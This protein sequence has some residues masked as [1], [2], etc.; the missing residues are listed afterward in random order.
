MPQPESVQRARRDLGNKLRALRTS[1]GF[2]GKALAAICDWHPSKVSRIENGRCSASVDD[3][4]AWTQACGRPEDAPE[5]VL[6]VE[7]I[8]TMYLEWREMEKKGLAKAQEHVI[9]L[10]EDTLRYKAYAI[11]YIPG[12]FQTEDYTRAV[13][14]GI[15]TRRGL[16]DEDFDNAVAI[17][18]AKQKYL[19]S[20]QFRIVLEEDVLYTRYAGR[21]VMISQLTRLI[22]VADY[23]SVSL[24]IIPRDA[25]R[26]AAHKA[27]DF[28]IFDDRTVQVE[29]VSAFLTLKQQHEVKRYLDDFHYL[30][31]LA[32]QHGSALSLLAKAITAY[33]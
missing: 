1:R 24:G 26:G 15:R 25:A 10:W 3:I 9:P 21:S 8:A 7:N 32:A 23:S 2:T 19:R 27:H 22:Q 5:L 14:N 18:A 17:R 31:E 13:L 16:G 33:G 11:S 29:I 4:R 20:G 6:A 12:P 28:W 30:N